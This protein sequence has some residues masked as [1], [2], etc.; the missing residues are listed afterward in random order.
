[1]ENAGASGRRRKIGDQC[2]VPLLNFPIH[3]LLPQV[4]LSGTIPGEQDHPGGVLV[5]AMDHMRFQCFG[6]FLLP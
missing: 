6:I 1:M 5:E 3:E 4:R 2:T